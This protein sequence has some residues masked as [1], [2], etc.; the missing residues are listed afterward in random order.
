MRKKVKNVNLVCGF[1]DQLSQKLFIIW[2]SD[3]DDNKDKNVSF[4]TN[5]T[6]LHK[7]NSF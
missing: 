2:R 6:D 3:G 7:L 1:L 5:P 4:P